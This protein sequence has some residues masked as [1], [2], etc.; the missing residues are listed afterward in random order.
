MQIE[1]RGGSDVTVTGNI[2]SIEDSIQLKDAINRVLEQGT[3]TIH[4]KIKD[5]MSMPST[6]IGFLMTLAHQEKVQ[7]TVNVG[8]SRLHILLEELGLL[9]QF[10]VRMAV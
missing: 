4:L 7:L 3:R 5:S 9:E 6:A 1:H 2:K 10:N 8:D